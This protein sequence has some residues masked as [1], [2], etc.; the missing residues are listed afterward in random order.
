MKIEDVSIPFWVIQNKIK[1]EK[2]ELFEFK[3]HYFLY[4][5]LRDMSRL[6]VIKKAAQIG[7]SV[8]MNLKAFFVASKLNLS[9]IYTMPS[10]S[11]VEEFSKTK[12]DRI[13]QSN[14]CIRKEIRLDNVGLKQVGETFIY[15]KGTR[16]KAAPISTTTDILIHDEIDRSDMEII[17]IYSSRIAASKFKGK[18]LLS[19]PSTTNVGVDLAWKKS[20]K[21]EWHITCGD[22]KHEQYLEWEKNVDEIRGIY[23]CQNCGKEITDK[24]RMKGRWLPTAEGEWSGY[25]ISQMMASWISAEELIKE[26]E[27]KGI[28]YF[29]NFVLGEP[30]SVGTTADFRQVI[31]D[32]WTVDTLDSPPLYMGVDIGKR[33]HWVLGDKKGIFKIGVCE[34]RE[35]L[36]SVINHYNPLVVMDSGPERTWA[37]E[38]KRKYPKVFLCFYRHDKNIAQMIQWGGE[39]GNFE[40]SKNWGYVWIDRNRL[41][42]DL[43]YNM[44][45][46][47]V[48]FALHREDLERMIKHWETMRRVEEEVKGL[49]TSRYIWETTTGVNHFAS[50]LWFYYIA[51][52]R[53]DIKTSF[54]GE[55]G[56]RPRQLVNITAEGEHKIADLKEIWEETNL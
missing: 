36:E 37:E 49:R 1:N 10:D 14:E 48:L 6:Q 34:S 47:E 16:S 2:N 12:A 46:G 44:M 19:N 26:K 22:C 21:K 7:L 54:G 20:D 8:T 29:R 53:A 55:L 27:E 32:N 31:T 5:P 15:Y 25:H 28:E 41:I 50:A 9:V 13:F 45:R 56:A 39:K 40:D 3:S 30:Y 24:E 51:R 42:D 4:D 38:F 35:E 11:D 43:I 23:V 17:E 52:K 33:K 18:W